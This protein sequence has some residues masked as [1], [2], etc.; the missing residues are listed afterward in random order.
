MG[1]GMVMLM[2]GISSFFMPAIPGIDPLFMVLF[3]VVLLFGGALLLGL[4]QQGIIKPEFD[5]ISLIKCADTPKCKYVK[6]KKFEKD[7][8][9]FKPVDG[10]CDICN[11]PLHIAAIFEIEKKPAPEKGS[12]EKKDETHDLPPLPKNETTQS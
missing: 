5:N 1:A 2:L 7:D 12:E 3:G 8:Y 10:K 6:A 11:S 4:A 9:V